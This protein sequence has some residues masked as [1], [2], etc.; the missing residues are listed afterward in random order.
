MPSARLRAKKSVLKSKGGVKLTAVKVRCVNGGEPHLF[1]AISTP[2]LR[3]LSCVRCRAFCRFPPPA[4]SLAVSLSRCFFCLIVS[5]SL[6]SLPHPRSL[7]PPGVHRCKQ[8]KAS[9]KKAKAAK[10]PANR[11]GSSGPS[12]LCSLIVSAHGR[13]E[14]GE[15][16]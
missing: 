2:R 8:G 15:T 14:G 4:L 1:R 12:K 13:G 9:P 7:S 16:K 6:L 3:S 5:F 10:K 11:K